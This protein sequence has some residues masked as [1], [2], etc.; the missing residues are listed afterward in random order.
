MFAA[1]VT[2]ALL[3]GCAPLQKP[4]L[5][6]YGPDKEDGA[7]VTEFEIPEPT[8]YRI[9]IDDS[10][11]VNVWQH[12]DLSKEVTVRPD[13]K[14]SYLLIGD[15]QAAGLSVAELDKEVTRKFEEYAKKLKD[16][17][18]EGPPVKKEYTIGLA[19]ELDISVWKI[20]DLSAKVIVRPDGN[21]SYPLVGDIRAYGKTL[22]EFDE[23]LTKAL[24][25]YVLYPSV[26]VMVVKFG[27]IE[28]RRITFVTEFI[29]TFLEE[30]PEIS[31]IVKSFGSRKVIVLGQV[32]DPGIYDLEGNA[33][34]LDGIAYADG[35]TDAAVKDNIM[36]IRGNIRHNPTVIKINAWDIIKR[37]NYAMNIPLQSQDI[38]YVPRSVVGNINVF[39]SQ[40]SPAIEEL[41]DSIT[42]KSA[43]EEDLM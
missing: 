40:I 43:I 25:E 18:Q 26:S 21:I 38:I 29:S 19:D 42:L 12:P 17:E 4:Q 30:K 13:G 27:E 20:P 23:E 39:L 7:I 1:L 36:L 6:T 33:R 22:T 10:L 41:N 11:E 37:G 28:R 3:S 34:I 35:F 31:I 9:G 14:I 5:I 24:G 16:V 15:V 2:A 32:D 8:D